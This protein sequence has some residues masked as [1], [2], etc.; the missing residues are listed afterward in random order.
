[1][2]WL[3]VKD[4]EHPLGGLPVLRIGCV[5]VATHQLVAGSAGQTPAERGGLRQ[6]GRSNGYINVL[7]VR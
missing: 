2:V 7:I 1:M 5:S 4:R 6:R 3:P